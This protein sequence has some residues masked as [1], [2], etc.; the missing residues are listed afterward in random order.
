MLLTLCDTYKYTYM[1]IQ[2]VTRHTQGVYVPILVGHD[3][4]KVCMSLTCETH[5][6]CESASLPVGHAKATGCAHL[7]TCTHVHT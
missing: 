6:G 1:P 7:Q 2:A 3:T 5:T 4:H